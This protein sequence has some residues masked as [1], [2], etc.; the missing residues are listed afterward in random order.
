[1]KATDRKLFA[2]LMTGV[3]EFYG[4]PAPSAFVL[5]VWWEAMR[6]FDLDAVRDALN[7]HCVNPDTGQFLPK[8]ADVVRMIGGGTQDAALSAWSRLDRA[9]R[10]V[11]TFTSVVFDDPLIHT[12]IAE[13][14]GWIALGT[15]TEDEW[16]F[17]RNEFVTRYR[18]Q[19]LRGG[20]PAYPPVLIGIAEAHNATEGQ[21]IAPP[22]LLGDPERA[23]AVQARGSDKPMLQVTDYLALPSAAA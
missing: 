22:K 19:K 17:L 2:E 16:P 9:V 21:R 5:G 18:A 1:M 12:V 8:P 7:R 14:G 13:M 6:P 3:Y 10:Q 20:W 4:K 15:K 23:R 11:G